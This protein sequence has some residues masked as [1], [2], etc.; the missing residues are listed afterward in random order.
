[1]KSADCIGRLHRCSVLAKS[2]KEVS[3]RICTSSATRNATQQRPGGIKTAGQDRYSL[4]L[5]ETSGPTPRELRGTIAKSCR[6]KKTVSFDSAG[7]A[8]S[9]VQKPHFT[10][11]AALVLCNRVS[12]IRSVSFQA[13]DPK[14]Q[15]ASAA[16]P[17]HPE[18]HTR[19]P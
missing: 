18:S 7:R 9:C 12:R 2:S 19:D 3:S 6:E 14:F 17:H 4:M 5:L 11:A 10:H 15:F 8:H 13:S 16:S 1:L